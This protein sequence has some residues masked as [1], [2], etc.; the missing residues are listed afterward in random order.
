MS[1]DDFVHNPQTF[2][3]VSHPNFIYVGVGSRDDFDR[4]G[5]PA[6]DHGENDVGHVLTKSV[7]ENGVRVIFQ[8]WLKSLTAEAYL[9]RRT[10]RV[11]AANDP[12]RGD[13]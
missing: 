9:R 1:T 6:I 3:G 5:V 12:D 13:D 7:E 11:D 2:V 10:K 4:I 8:F